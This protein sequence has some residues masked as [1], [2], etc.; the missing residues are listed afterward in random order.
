[1]IVELNNVATLF[2]GWIVTD[3]VNSVF[4]GIGSFFSDL[5]WVFVIGMFLLI[6]MAAASTSGK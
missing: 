5:F 2:F 3:F 1:M 4:S 6:V